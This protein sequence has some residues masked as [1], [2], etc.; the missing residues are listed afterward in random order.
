M[1]GPQSIETWGHALCSL[2]IARAMLYFVSSLRFR[3]DE[4]NKSA[5]IT[6]GIYSAWHNL[7]RPGP[8]PIHVFRQESRGGANR[9]WHQ[10]AG[11]RLSPH[12]SYLVRPSDSA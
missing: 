12:H 8:R 4:S 6:E 3:A 5:R 1:R 10:E 11:R 9:G 2:D 7:R